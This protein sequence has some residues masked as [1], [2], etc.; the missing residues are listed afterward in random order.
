MKLYYIPFIIT[1]SFLAGIGSVKFDSG[2]VVLDKK[3]HIRQCKRNIGV[4]NYICNTNITLEETKKDWC[5]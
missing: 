5:R 3:E 1:F 2:K 4:G